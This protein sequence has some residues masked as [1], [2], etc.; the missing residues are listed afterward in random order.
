MAEAA[1]LVLQHA[2]DSPEL[3]RKYLSILKNAAEAG[4]VTAAQVAYLEDRIRVFKG[5]PQRFGT[6]FAWDRNGRSV[7]TQ[8]K[9]RID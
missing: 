7:R 2:I 8:L 1:W 5:R 9:T 6:Q 3:Q 4:E